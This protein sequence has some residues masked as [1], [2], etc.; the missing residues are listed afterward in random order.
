[1]RFA[2]QIPAASPGVEFRRQDFSSLAWACQRRALNALDYSM[3]AAS[4]LLQFS[5]AWDITAATN[6]SFNSKWL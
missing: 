6:A 5:I 4:G 2:K 3:A 1:M